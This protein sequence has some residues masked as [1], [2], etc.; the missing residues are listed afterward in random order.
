[1]IFQLGQGTSVPPNSTDSRF[2]IQT[3]L[4][5]E[6]LDLIPSLAISE[7][8]LQNYAQPGLWTESGEFY[9]PPTTH[10]IAT[11]EDLTDMLDHASEDIYG[12]D[13]DAGDEQGQD[14]PFTGRWTATST[15]DVYMVDTPKEDNNDDKK[16]LI[17]DKPAEAPLER[18]RQRCRS[19]SRR[20]KDTN[21]GTGDNNTPDD[22]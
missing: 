11:V 19:K 8:S 21:T 5:N 10:F 16:D 13:D 4:L 18:R 9:V 20:E 22:A 15:Y 1:M 2:H 3:S 7:E 17:E 12:M 6:A 14:P